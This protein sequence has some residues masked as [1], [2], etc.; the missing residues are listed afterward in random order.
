MP[1]TVNKL[2]FCK[3]RSRVVDFPVV[4]HLRAH[5][6][7]WWVKILNSISRLR[8]MLISLNKIQYQFKSTLLSG[9]CSAFT[10]NKIPIKR[11]SAGQMEKNVHQF[12]G[13]Y[14][15]L[16]LAPDFILACKSVDA[17]KSQLL[18]I[19]LNYLYELPP[20][21][22]FSIAFL[23][24]DYGNYIWHILNH[25][26]PLL[27]RFHLIHHTDKDLDLTTAFRFYFGELIGSVFSGAP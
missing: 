15:C 13:L 27:W 17:Y 14:S 23:V 18:H 24:L 9:Y 22:G 7:A 1:F 2:K 16:R 25:K 21:V 3:P 6:D 10:W 4:Q 19:G 20:W 8:K 26:V 11:K 12:H 5:P